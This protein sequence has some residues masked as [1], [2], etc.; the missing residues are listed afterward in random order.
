LNAAV[1][2]QSIS[3]VFFP[4]FPVSVSFWIDMWGSLCY[5][6]ATIVPKKTCNCLITDGQ[7]SLKWTVNMNLSDTKFAPN[8]KTKKTHGIVEC[9]K[10]YSR[11]R[12]FSYNAPKAISYTAVKLI[13]EFWIG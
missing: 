10:S 6:M 11:G 13:T 7:A 2:L 12:H 4:V 9:E 5:G 8:P 1:Y 3:A